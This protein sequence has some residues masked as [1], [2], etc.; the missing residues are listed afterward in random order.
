MHVGSF[1]LEKNHEFLLDIFEELKETNPSI[2]LICVGDGM[3][4]KEI[5]NQ[6]DDRKLRN[7]VFLSGFEKNIHP[8]LVL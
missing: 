6:I 3:L 2:K 1:S 5:E 8:Y 4:F 7:T